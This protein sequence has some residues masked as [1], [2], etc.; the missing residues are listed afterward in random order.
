MPRI[1]LLLGSNIGDKRKQLQSALFLLEKKLGKVQMKSH[2]YQTKAWGNESQDDFYNMAVL[3]ETGVSPDGALEKIFTIEKDLGRERNELRYQPRTIDIDILFYDSLVM[4]KEALTI[5]HP[6][7][8]AR[9]F[10]LLPLMDLMP[11]FIHPVLN[12]EIRVL[13]EECNDDLDC[14]DIGSL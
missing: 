13:L 4:H 10:T 8:Q 1:V 12:K 2:L 5:P 6:Q 9:R 3:V 11:D 14:E 7:I